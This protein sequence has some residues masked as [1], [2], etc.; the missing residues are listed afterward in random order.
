MFET[1]NSSIGS[2]IILVLFQKETTESTGPLDADGSV[3]PHG[4][5]QHRTLY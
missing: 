4:W 5:P 2:I 3:A 1:M